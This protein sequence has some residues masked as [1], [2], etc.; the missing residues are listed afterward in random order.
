MIK[1]KYLIYAFVFSFMLIGCKKHELNSEL[2]KSILEYQKKVPIPVLKEK[3]N[4][5][6]KFRFI[7]IVDFSLKDKDTVVHIVRRPSGIR[8]DTRYYGLYEI[9][10]FTPVVI[11]DEYN[12]GKKFIKSKIRNSS[13]QRFE[14][15]EN[16]LHFTDYPPVYSYVIKNDKI[17]L[18]SIDTVSNNWIR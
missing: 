16:K 6:E 8:K 11:D 18:I 4:Y 14:L 12:L 9:N 13:L 2:E 3:N 7:Y 5:S 17:N 10:K 1:I 15:A